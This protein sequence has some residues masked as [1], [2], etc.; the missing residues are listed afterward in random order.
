MFISYQR[1][2][3]L[4]Q[5]RG[6]TG[7]SGSSVMS[8]IKLEKCRSDSMEY[9]LEAR[10]QQMDF[11]KEVSQKSPSLSTLDT[12]GTAY[13][14]CV[15]IA[16]SSYQSMLQMN[17]TSVPVLRSYAQFLLE[18]RSSD[19]VR[20]AGMLQLEADRSSCPP[21]PPGVAIGDTVSAGTPCHGHGGATGRRSV[22]TRSSCLPLPT[23][24]V[25]AELQLESASLAR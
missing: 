8:Q 14:K 24:M 18:V 5:G 15:R 13:E 21:S 6:T 20:V 9:G 22:T 25:Q 17:P 1:L 11:W 19:C 2:Q 3:Q 12:I 4:R 7:T 23:Q 10:R 16:E